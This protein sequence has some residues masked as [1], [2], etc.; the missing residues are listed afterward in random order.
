MTASGFE[1][2]THRKEIAGLRPPPKI[3]ANS[4]RI[5]SIEDIPAFK[6]EYLRF[7]EEHRELGEAKLAEYVSVR[8]IVL[9]L[10]DRFL[11]QREDGRFELE[12]VLH[13][14]ICPRR[15]TSDDPIFA[16]H[17]LWLVD[18]RLEYH[19][20]LASDIELDR[21]EQL[22]NSESTRPDIL[23]FKQSLAFANEHP[24]S[25]AVILEFKKPQRDNYSRASNPVVQM[26]NYVDQLKEGKAKDPRGRW[27]KIDD[28]PCYGYAIC[29]LTPSLLKLA[30]ITAGWTPMPDGRG[31]YGYNDKLKF[32]WELMDYTKMVDNAKK[33]NR[34]LFERLGLPT[35]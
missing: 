28:T 32:Y 17:N 23:L 9:D 19:A 21:I 22:E 2:N 5:R 24:H 15:A 12:E 8:R 31:F 4:Y 14:I 29:D 10:F 13:A 7:V 30:S 27:L 18:E 20:F 11:G 33:R 16:S 26:E 35:R 3:L 6:E 25:S 34:A 1:E